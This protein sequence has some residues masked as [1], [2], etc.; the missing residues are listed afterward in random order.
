MLAITENNLALALIGLDRYEEA[1]EVTEAALARPGAAALVGMLNY[2]IFY[3]QVLLGRIDAAR[4]TVQRAL[5]WWQRDSALELAASALTLLL[6][7]MGRAADGGRVY[8]VCRKILQGDEHALARLWRARAER[9]FVD[10]GVAAEDLERWACEGQD[11]NRNALLALFKS[12][13]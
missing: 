3:A 12:V 2:P 6:I 7:R 11:M 8:G 1:I 4:A 13:L 5:P 10:A 9:H